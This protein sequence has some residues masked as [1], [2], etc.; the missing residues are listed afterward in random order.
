MGKAWAWHGMCE[1]AFNVFSGLDTSVEASY[2]P[3]QGTDFTL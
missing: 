1:L 3:L 2:L